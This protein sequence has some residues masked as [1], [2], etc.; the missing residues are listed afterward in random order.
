MV[1]AWRGDNEGPPLSTA[2]VFIN[3][4]QAQAMFPGATV[5]A[6]SLETFMDELQRAG[7][8]ALENLPVVTQDMGNTW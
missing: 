4:Q 3:F 2:E 8:A 5:V 6:S 7:P 1:Y